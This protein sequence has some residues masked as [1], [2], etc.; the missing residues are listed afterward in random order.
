MLYLR[1]TSCCAK[2][3]N[4]LW[5]LSNSFCVWE[6]NHVVFEFKFIMLMLMLML[7][8]HEVKLMLFVSSNSWY[9]LRNLLQEMPLMFMCKCM[10]CL[11]L[12][13]CS[14][15]VQIY[16]VF[17]L[18]SMLCLSSSSNLYCAWIQIHVVFEF[19]SMLCLS[20][21]SR[22]AWGQIFVVF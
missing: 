1:S 17:Q 8:Q 4:I 19:K 10:L 9:V 3:K 20:S 6:Q 5:L 21:S 7:M 22:C 11:S 13:T 14:N 12:N 2:F 18:K 16:V 15:W